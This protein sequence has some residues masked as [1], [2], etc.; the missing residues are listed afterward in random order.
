MSADKVAV[1]FIN[2][3]GNFI[4]LTAAIK[5]LRNWGYKHIALLTDIDNRAN[6]RNYEFLKYLH[7]DAFDEMILEYDDN[8]YDKLFLCGWSV[9]RSALPHLRKYNRKANIIHWDRVGV[10][11]VQAY[12]SMVGASWQ[13][14]DGYL[15]NVADEPILSSLDS[16]PRIALSQPSGSG[17]AVKK[18]WDKFPEL[19]KALVDMGFSVVLLGWPGE[20]DGCVGENFIGKTSLRE[21]G[22]ILEQCDLLIAPSTGL[23]VVADAVNTP[24]LLLEGPMFTSRAHPLVAKYKIVRKY[25]ACA[26]C[27]QTPLWGL[28]KSP[29]CM[30]FISVGDILHEMFRFMDRLGESNYIWD[31]TQPEIPAAEAVEMDNRKVAYIVSCFN[32]YHL[33]TQFLQSFK[34]CNPLPGDMFVWNDGSTDPRVREALLNFEVDGIKIRYFET[35]VKHEK[36]ADG[37][38]TPTCRINNL[39]IDK[40]LEADKECDFD[41]VVLIDPD[42]IMKSNWMQVLIKAFEEAESEHKIATASALNNAKSYFTHDNNTTYET[43]VSKYRLR[44]GSSLSWITRMSFLKDGFGK[45]GKDWTSSDIGKFEELD[46]KGYRNL[47]L[48]PSLI[49]HA[50]ALDSCMRPKPGVVGEDFK[51]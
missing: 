3:I 10:H 11:E 17:Q 4:F 44:G 29:N 20:L 25:I 8:K 24:V 2:G 13:D 45:Y 30:E 27:F 49:Q 32:R 35:P 22:K 7:R 40:V 21:A 26:P 42:T 34:D 33:L 37:Y 46:A 43:S 1:G 16:R 50:G 15:F 19:S 5:V 12:L 38:A 36:T 23:T 18:R 28:C 51:I 39:M 9:P 47:I 41:Y 14:F 6:R 48:M 31:I